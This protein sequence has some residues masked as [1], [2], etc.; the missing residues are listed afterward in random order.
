MEKV[1]R[2]VRIGPASDRISGQRIGVEKG[3]AEGLGK[4]LLWGGSLAGIPLFGAGTAPVHGT[5]DG[6]FPC[7]SARAMTVAGG[8]GVAIAHERVS[9]G[10]KD[11]MW[12]DASV[13]NI[14][15]GS[16][17]VFFGAFP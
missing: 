17:F 9:L 6:R 16:H 4:T 3:F 12:V 1:F 11:F 13:S 8:N 5:E 2:E 15:R 7:V 14:G 10:K